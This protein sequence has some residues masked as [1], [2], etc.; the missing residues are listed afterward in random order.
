MWAAA[1]LGDDWKKRIII[2]SDKTIVK[3]RM[4]ID[5]KLNIVDKKSLCNPPEWIQYAACRLMSPIPSPPWSHLPRDALRDAGSF[6]D[7]RIWITMK[8]SSSITSFSTAGRIGAGWS[9]LIRHPHG[10]LRIPPIPPR[11]LE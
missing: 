1:V 2:T 4:L 9:V 10:N 7:G 11:S 5:D 8:A 3:G 6:F